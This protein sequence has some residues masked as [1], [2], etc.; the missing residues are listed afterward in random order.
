M[1]HW[2]VLGAGSLG[3]LWA[4]RLAQ[5]K[6]PVT[7]LL[8]DAGR[9]AQYQR[10][11]GLRLI[12]GPNHYHCPLPA[13][14]LAT[15]GPIAHLLL[16]CKAY[17]ALPAAQA[18]AS[19]L[20]PGAT[21]LLLQNGLGSQQAVAGALPQARCIAVSSTEG[22]WRS[23]E[24]VITRAGTGQNWL[25]DGA[26]PPAWL[27]DLRQA[28]IPFEWTL[29]INTRLWRKLA[30]NCAIN[31]L[32]VILAC[33]NGELASHRDA[34]E[35]LCQELARLLQACGQSEAA[36]GLS[37]TVWQVIADTAGNYS[38][39]LQ[40]VRSGRPTEV[41]YL[42]GYA[43]S[44]GRLHRLDLPALQALAERLAACLGSGV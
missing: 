15:C 37:E 44:Q 34:V 14:D 21:V 30:I 11:G 3:G 10:A 13:E 23:P 29:A 1:A 8:R 19:R 24:G 18:L 33:R 20:I 22:A 7:L 35:P 2:H 16:A 38:S 42:L 39:M 26:P 41:D 4:C 32:T 9:V 5:A 27:E 12:D 31:P 28:R 36:T 6:L 40:D 43:L 25:G 17:D